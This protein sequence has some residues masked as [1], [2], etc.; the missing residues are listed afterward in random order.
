MI[1]ATTPFIVL[2]V[3][4]LLWALAANPLVKDAGRMMF[5]IGLFW[6]VYAVVGHTVKLFA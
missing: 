2:I 6:S 1:L 3:G 4:L 5:V